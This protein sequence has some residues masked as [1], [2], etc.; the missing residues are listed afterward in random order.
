MTTIAV[1]RVDGHLSGP[2]A[3]GSAGHDVDQNI[4]ILLDPRTRQPV[5]PATS[6]VGAL[7]TH[8]S[9]P[10][11]WLGP[12]P[13]DTGQ[14]GD[15][16]RTPSRLWA[17]STTLDAP[18]SVGTVHRTAIDGW[19]GAAAGTALRSESVVDAERTGFRWA[20]CHDGAVDHA[21]LDELAAWRCEI[22]ARRTTGLGRLIVD[23]VSAVNV[24][25]AEVTGLTWWLAGRD[26]W[27]RPGED[28]ARLTPPGEVI[29]RTGAD[30]DP[31]D[32]LEGWTWRIVDPVHVG[33]GET[34]ENGRVD[35]P[36]A[37][38]STR[39]KEYRRAPAGPSPGGRERLEIPGSAWKG[40]FRHRV[41]MVL[42]SCDATPSGTDDV[43]HVL[44]GH[45]GDRN[46]S[47][48]Q[49]NRRRGLLRFRSSVVDVTETLTRTHVA[50]DRISG[51]AAESKLFSIRSVPTGTAQLRIDGVAGLPESVRNLLHHV[52]WDLHEGLIGVGAFTTRGYG[53]LALTGP[54]P[55]TQAVDVPAVT[56][57]ASGV[58]GAAMRAPGEETP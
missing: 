26:R 28:G 39:V 54:L 40:I 44:F 12:E 19:R 31:A 25:L 55:Q 3:I 57:W 9:D 5:L 45:H 32:D 23:K 56:A 8:L 50:I 10:V 14:A 22:G 34:T 7:R 42:R 24:D 37:A 21:L 41:S 15:S 16:Q 35:G 6:L 29:V 2:W 53:T 17:L 38:R 33:T 1:I 58:I 30:A 51:G 13:D 4:P 18:V 49:G 36:P 47:G 46:K 43:L 27:L 20:L 52:V 11:G 48:T